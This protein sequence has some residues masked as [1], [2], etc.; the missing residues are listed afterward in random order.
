[1]YESTSIDWNRADLAEGRKYL[2]AKGFLGVDVANTLAM[3]DITLAIL[4][5]IL[6]QMNAQLLAAL[7][8]NT[9]A[10]QDVLKILRHEQEEMAG[11]A[12]NLKDAAVN[13]TR[14]VEEQCNALQTAVQKLDTQME[15]LVSKADAGAARMG[16]A[17]NDGL[18]TLQAIP[19]YADAARR[20]PSATLSKHAA[21]IAYTH[22]REKQVTLRSDNANEPPTWA[23]LTDKETL[24]KICLALDKVKEIETSDVPVE[25]YKPLGTSR[26]RSG[27]LVIHMSS[28]AAAEWMKIPAHMRLFLSE[29]SATAK[30]QPKSYMV[31]ADF[32]P[33]SFEPETG[34]TQLEDGNGYNSGDFTSA[35]YIKDPTR[36]KDGQL[37]AHVILGLA[38]ANAANRAIR[39]GLFIEGKKVTCRKLLSEP[40]RCVKCQLFNTGHVA[41]TCKSVHETCARCGEMHRTSDCKAE[42][43]NRACSNCRIHGKSHR[44]HG[45]ADRTCPIFAT[46]LQR[47]LQ[48]NP[49]A[50]YAYFPTHDDPLS[51]ETLDAPAPDL[52]DQAATFQGG[53]TAANRPQPT[54]LRPGIPSQSAAF[55][56]AAMTAAAT[57]SFGGRNP[58]NP[59]D[60]YRQTTL[61][62]Q[63]IAPQ[64]DFEQMTPAQPMERPARGWR[65]GPATIPA[66]AIKQTC[67]PG[68]PG[69]HTMNQ[70][71]H[72]YWRGR[73]L[74]VWQ[75][76]MNKNLLAQN[77]FVNTI[78]PDTYNIALIQEP[79]IDH[80]G[81]SRANLHYTT[82]YPTP[83]ATSTGATRSVILVANTI[84]SSIWS[85]ISLP[86]HDVTGI[87]LRLPD[88]ILR[89]I[90]IY[91]DCN[92][93]NSLDV[94]DAFLSDPRQRN[95]N[96]HP[97]Q[98]IWAGDFNRHHPL[99]DKD[100]NQHLFTARNGMLTN[101]LLTMLGRY[102]MFMALPKDLPTLRAHRTKNHTR[103]DNVFCSDALVQAFIR[104]T[105][106]PGQ[107]PINTDHF[108][109]QFAIQ[110]EIG[111]AEFVP[112]PNWHAV[113]WEE[114]RKTLCTALEAWP[115]IN[116]TNAA[117]IEEEIRHIDNA[118]EKAITQHVQM[119]KPCPNSKRWWTNELSQLRK[120]LRKAQSCSY[121]HR[122][123]PD[124][125]IHENMRTAR[126]AFS[127]ELQRVKRDHWLTWL[128]ALTPTDVWNVQRMVEGP[129]SDGGRAR[130]P[131]LITRTNG[132][133][134]RA[135]TNKEKAKALHREFFPDKTAP[136]PAV[137]EAAYPQ[138]AYEWSPL[139]DDILYQT[140]KRLKPYKAR[141]PGSIPN[142]VYKNNADLLVPRLG[143]V[144]R[145]GDCFNYYP[146]GWNL[147]HS[148]VLRKPGKTDYTAAASF[149]P[150]VLSKG[151]AGLENAARTLHIT[152]QAE[153]AGILPTSQFGARPGRSTTDAIHTVVKVIKDAWRAGKVAS[154]L[155][156]DVKGAFPSVDL[157]V[158]IHEMRMA[159]VP[160]E[161]TDW[162]RRRYKG[163]QAVIAFDG[164]VSEPFEVK[165]GL[166]QGD[167]H[168]GISYM[169]YNAGLAKIPQP[170]MGEHGVTFV[171]D[172]TIVTMGKS[173]RDTHRALRGLIQGPNGI[174]KWAADHNA[175]F[176]PAKYQLL[177]ATRKRV[178]DTFRTRRTA[179][180]PRPDF[181]LGQHMI[182]SAKSVK[183]LGIH[184]DREL[185]WKE[186]RAAAVGKGMVWL[187]TVSRLARPSRGIRPEQIRRLYLA[188][189]VPRMLYGADVFL[190]ASTSRARRSATR[191]ILPKLRS[192]QRKAAILITGALSSTPTDTLD[193]HANL[194]PVH[195][196]VTKT[197][198]RAIARLA[199]LPM[200]HPLNKAVTNAGMRY[201]QK[202]QTPLH[203]LTNEFDIHAEK[204]EKI[205]AVRFGLGW[206]S[207]TAIE[208]R[209]SK[210][211][212]IK[213]EADDNTRWKVYTDGSG[214]DGYI[215]AAAVLYDGDTEMATAR[216]RLGTSEEHT[217][218]E[219]EGLGLNLA[220]GLL[221]EHASN[222]ITGQV[223]IYA[224][225]TAAI[226]ATQSREST[227]SHYIWDAL[228]TA[229]DDLL[230]TEPDIDITF[231]WAPGHCNIHGNERAD[232]L[233]RRA[234]QKRCTPAAT[235]KRDMRLPNIL[236]GTLPLSKSALIQANTAKIKAAT[237]S[238]WRASPRYAKTKYVLPKAL[239]GG[240]LA[241]VS[242]SPRKLVSVLFQLRS[243]HS[244][245]ARHLYKIGRAASPICPC[246]NRDDET[247]AHYLLRCPAHHNARR[248]L[249]RCVGRNARSIKALLSDPNTVP[250]LLRFVLRTRRF[251]TVFGDLPDVHEPTNTA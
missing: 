143:A 169:I 63:R 144:F 81:V 205:S 244:I 209:S 67:P 161:H 22:A 76:N 73:R 40:V 241:L 231:K 58:N 148:L 49:D 248:E 130:I 19:S 42:D 194:L 89:I 97:I 197:R 98:Y 100:R 215:G 236:R 54:A 173:F 109:V 186:Q 20:T 233:A 206:K 37:V 217:V 35:K 238:E 108:P 145:A 65:H 203:E 47:S 153:R 48:R 212:A 82:I 39:H 113:D 24:A 156:M 13:L 123:I 21:A 64:D 87:E 134:V 25:V 107:R 96:G 207:R 122:H 195:H 150:I 191:D 95:R 9:A 56:A 38:T 8:E 246:C 234:A 166:D 26:T 17:T 196:L 221:R 176:G 117:D 5:Y 92:H 213:G 28:T 27:Q 146:K 219:G 180:M 80:R 204:M 119:T 30:H 71:T 137:N 50:R 59:P 69:E 43:T 222:G 239:S 86:S 78:T 68:Q 51:W 45:A 170:E 210:E 198:H 163:R 138:A 216:K 175:I 141:Q 164:F 223:A 72:S 46:T 116:I 135:T 202:H 129:P 114:F 178:K 4:P 155:C 29:F 235:T 104:C 187:T 31:V 162:M 41:K 23:K 57:R 167:P 232:E 182:K 139:T 147:V 242:E 1:M 188:T 121:T 91:N 125:P 181:K 61:N 185:R 159:G 218:Y 70:N 193:A 52:E 11:D 189:C 83:H 247:V 127:T 14:T 165:N 225:N 124:H 249:H 16:H 158:L 172:E 32:V 142:C 118:L 44:G 93:N 105:T 12:E 85:Q 131:D 55:K 149:R 140:I 112:R 34:L 224:D 3:G 240:F 133:N 62:F 53:N 132:R 227:P 111:Y 237:Q 6:E 79:H 15:D 106:N 214:I 211:E 60:R 251:Q 201:V 171:D 36:R 192:I 102:R 7:S 77:Q 136:A 184:I 160:K 110:A 33:V 126:K 75:Q 18:A 128:D 152:T 230:S 103:V 177:D 10:I 200:A 94:L 90:N 220:V 250:H 199:T 243:G 2:I 229:I 183:L 228:H 101:K 88:G 168:S 245:L 154:V 190:N 157:E 66:T 179:P 74:N 115:Q 84:P 99:W 174:D 226:T 120:K 208:I 151:H